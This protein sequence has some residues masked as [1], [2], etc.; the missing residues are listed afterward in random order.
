M[1]FNQFTG[2]LFSIVSSS[3]G[4]TKQEPHKKIPIV[5]RHGRKSSKRG[6]FFKYERVKTARVT[7]EDAYHVEQDDTTREV[8]IYMSAS[9]FRTQFLDYF[10][11]EFTGS[12]FTEI[13][14][15]FFTKFGIAADAAELNGQKFGFF[16]APFEIGSGDGD[17]VVAPATGSYDLSHGIVDHSTKRVKITFSNNTPTG[18]YLYA[19][20]GG[21]GT[22]TYVQ[23]DV[24]PEWSFFV[25]VTQS[26]ASNATSSRPQSIVS[27]T[28]H[29]AG[30]NADKHIEPLHTASAVGGNSYNWDDLITSSYAFSSS[31]SYGPKNAFN[32]LTGSDDGYRATGVSSSNILLSYDF[33]NKKR[34][35]GF[36]GS[37]GPN[38]SLEGQN[39]LPIINKVKLYFGDE[40]FYHKQIQVSGSMDGSTWT[41]LGEEA[42]ETDN[43]NARSFKF[44]NT[45]GYQYYGILFKSGSYKNVHQLRVTGIEYEFFPRLRKSDSQMFHLTSSLTSSTITGILSGSPVTP[46]VSL[47]YVKQNQDGNTQDISEGTYLEYTTKGKIFG[48]GEYGDGEVSSSDYDTSD[49]AIFTPFRNFIVYS[50]ESIVRS[51]SFNFSTSSA[52]HAS[53]SGVG[54]ILHYLQGTT[55]PS[56]SYSGA[57]GISSGSHLWADSAFTTPASSGY[58]HVPGTSEVLFAFKQGVTADVIPSAGNQT[59]QQ[60]PRFTSKS[61]H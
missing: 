4:S 32:G 27:D 59:Q 35:N 55:G 23:D 53:A 19:Q 45:R 10:T 28:L 46:E 12:A 22:Q 15:S 52:T 38:H 7:N 29:N 9:E 44:N 8:A 49:R 31:N 50:S 40:N 47:E 20:W 5:A 17:T 25:E 58:Y 6:G 43:S 14:A 41:G 54:T 3:V 21:L 39:S 51:G 34:V 13:S 37:V 61:L 26:Y 57:F 11:R 60:V 42:A 24:V 48:D 36:V 1:S 16:V 18:S 33:K 56:G 30:L 2:R